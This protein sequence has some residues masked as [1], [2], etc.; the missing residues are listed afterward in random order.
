MATLLKKRQDTNINDLERWVALIGGAGLI[1]YGLTRKDKVGAGLAA[2]GGT[3]AYRG[4][5]GHCPLY[6]ALGV[7]T[8]SRSGE[9]GT[10]S[11]AGVPYELGIRVDQ[12]VRIQRP[13]ADVYRFWRNLDNLP[14]FMH[15]IESINE[16]DGKTSHWVARGPAGF[17]VEWDAEIV[18]EIENQVI[19]WRSLPGSSVDNGG[20]VR[21]EPVGDNE[22]IVRISLQY[23][24]P[25]GS[26]GAMVARAFGED[27]KTTIREDLTRFKQLMETGTITT[28]S[29]STSSEWKTSRAKKT[30]DDSVQN[31]SEESFPASDAPS[32]TP[33]TV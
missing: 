15:H 18:N 14:R 1:G 32:W 10:G 16:K 25:A 21:F 11:R 30:D 20:S 8:A 17:K 12:E 29:A 26:L 9:K 28:K 13:V 27:P 4:S 5:S 22:T 31:A 2:L 6:Q 33:E 23:N 19:G 24:P 7:N 3:L